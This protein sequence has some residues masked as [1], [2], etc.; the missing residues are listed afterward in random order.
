M[1]ESLRPFH[2][3]LPVTDL[4][5][6][7]AFYCDLLACDKGRT[8]SRWIDLNFYGHQLTLHLVE[9]DDAMAPTNPVDG[10]SVPARHFGI[11]LAMDDWRRLASR[12]EESACE[13]LIPPK[14]RFEGEIGEQA[15]L[16]VIDPSGNALEFKSLANPAQLFA[17]TR[18]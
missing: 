10:D 6:A 18:P 2:L 16:F 15:T 3:A 7:E 13:F 11:V 4:D 14:V 17:H 1:T 5:A 12:L 9:S 8:A